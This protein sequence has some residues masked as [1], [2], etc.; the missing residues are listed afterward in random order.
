MTNED[1]FHDIAKTHV[2][3]TVKLDPHCK[4]CGTVE[5]KNP[6]G[7]SNISYSTGICIDCLMNYR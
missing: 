7:H 5:K 4:L 2:R 1:L 6:A 3:E